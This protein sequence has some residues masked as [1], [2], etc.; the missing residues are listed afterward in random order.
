MAHGKVPFAEKLF[1]E[2]IGHSANR[3]FPVVTAE[4]KSTIS[5]IYD[6]GTMYGL[7]PST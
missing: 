1:A 3:G 6:P 5:S 7:V 2:C 4:N